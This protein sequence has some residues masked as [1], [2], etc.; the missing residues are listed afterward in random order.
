MKNFY[1]QYNKYHFPEYLRKLT[2]RV[3]VICP[4]DKKYLKMSNFL[5][6]RT[7]SNLLSV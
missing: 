1:K 3:R 2:P 7:D 6:F 4:L 5:D